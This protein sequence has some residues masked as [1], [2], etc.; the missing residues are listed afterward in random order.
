MD[1]AEALEKERRARL[2][3]E[4]LMEQFKTELGDR[5]INS[6]IPEGRDVYI[7]FDI[8]ALDGAPGVYSARF[9]GAGA[10]DADNNAKLIRE[11]EALDAQGAEAAFVCHVVIAQPDG[12]YALLREMEKRG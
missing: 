10:S 9:A 11:L 7:T 4:K 5:I 6:I 3:A 8:D 1:I 2:A 12:K